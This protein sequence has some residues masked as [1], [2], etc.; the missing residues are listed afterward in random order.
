MD[1]ANYIKIISSALNFE[2]DSGPQ[3]FSFI[4]HIDLC[5]APFTSLDKIYFYLGFCG[6][7]ILEFIIFY[8]LI[9]YF[10]KKA[11]TG[12]KNA[13]RL[14]RMSIDYLPK[15]ISNKSMHE[16]KV[17]FLQLVLFLFTPTFSTAISTFNCINVEVNGSILPLMKKH[18]DIQCWVTKTNFQ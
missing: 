18:P 13:L 15:Y 7:L 6:L 4:A 8:L 16:Y 5:V 17:G 2:S 9:I 3:L 1:A 14:Q 11:N 10:S 12:N